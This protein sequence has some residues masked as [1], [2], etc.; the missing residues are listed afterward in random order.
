MDVTSL[1]CE[2]RWKKFGKT[3]TEEGHMVFFSEKRI[4]MSI[5]LDFLVTRT[6]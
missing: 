4:Y 1:D 6:S 2:M 3:T 5:E